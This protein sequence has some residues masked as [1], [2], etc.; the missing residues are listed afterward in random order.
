MLHIK[1]TIVVEGKYDRER[2]REITDAPIIV[3]GGFTLYKDKKRQPLGL[4]CC[5]L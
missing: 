3:T 4:P 1:E 5:R 2:L